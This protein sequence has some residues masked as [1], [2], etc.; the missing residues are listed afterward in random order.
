MNEQNAGVTTSI[1]YADQITDA[2]RAALS[3]LAAGKDLVVDVGTFLGA[4]AEALL[5]G[6]PPNGRLITVDKYHGLLKNLPCTA[7]AAVE[8]MPPEAIMAAAFAR[9]SSYQDRVTLVAGTSDGLAAIFRPGTADLIF[10]D[11]AHDYENVK[12]DIRAWL[13]ALKPDGILVGHDY[14]KISDGMEISKEEIEARSALDWDRETAVHWGVVR[15]V[16]ELFETFWV[17]QD[18]DSTVWYITNG[19]VSHE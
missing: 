4:S 14:D 8:N 5:K 3:G 1:R 9:L 6:M 12:A 19:G 15:A 13:P 7:R 2:D 16:R 11:A 18:P 10:I 17:E